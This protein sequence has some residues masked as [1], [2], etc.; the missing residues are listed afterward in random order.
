MKDPAFR[1]R[2]KARWEEVRDELLTTAN[3]TIDKYSA[4][5]DGS[6]QENFA[7]WK[8]WGKRAGYQSKWCSAANTYEKQ[9][10]YLKD[11]LT[12]RAAWIDKHI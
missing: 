5:L 12:K 2:L 4:L 8:I 7:V 9:I 11:F 3:Q 10:K 6:Q 1:K